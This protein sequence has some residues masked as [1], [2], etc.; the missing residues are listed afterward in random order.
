MCQK[1]SLSN[2]DPD[3]STGPTSIMGLLTA[4]IIT[5]LKTEGFAAQDI[6]SAVALMVG[7]YSLIVGLLKLGFILEY[8]SVPVLSG[9]LSAAA[10]TILLGQ[11][12]SLVGLSD[13]PSGTSAIISNVLSRIPEMEPLT[14]AI[15]FSG[16]LMLYI[17]EFIGKKW[18]KKN[19]AV[20]FACSSRAVI[21]LLIYTTISFLVN[22][23]RADPLWAIS[24]VKANG[25]Q[26]PKI[27]AGDLVSK[28]T[29]RAI[30]PL[31]ASALEHLAIGKAFGRKN[32]YAI[33]ESQELC[34]LGITNTINSL[35][36]AMSVG[37]A[38]S[39]TAVNSECGVKSPLSGA[40]TAGFILLTLY[41]LSGAL[42]WIP[43]ATLSAIIVRSTSS[44]LV[45]S[46][47]ANRLSLDHGRHTHHWPCFRIL[48]LLAYLVHGLC[49][50]D[51][52]LL[53]HAFCVYR[54]GHCFCGI[55][56]HRIHPGPIRIPEGQDFLSNKWPE[57]HDPARA[58]S[59]TF[60][61][62]RYIRSRRRH[63]G[64]FHRLNLL[65]QRRPHQEVSA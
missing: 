17:L 10:I 57:P 6:S 47:Q 5:D 52:L 19:A 61:C 31:V 64:Q 41:K 24:K 42:F 54:D 37:G 9:F 36:G 63:V 23:D 2:L 58:G 32:N 11:V 40:F 29:T 12:G 38:M 48:P 51:A 53:G 35:F 34:Y 7:I 49:S 4:E 20:K 56:Q 25:L 1:Q 27:P 26:A 14:I 60:C 3:L 28:V 44:C 21:L 62:G 65:P 18:G 50:F 16:I 30:A 8:I 13:V 39:R 33:D 43:K 45:T 55:V 15:G 46:D 22:K 59:C